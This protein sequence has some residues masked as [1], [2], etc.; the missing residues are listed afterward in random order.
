MNECA[1]YL[2]SI[3]AAPLPEMIEQDPAGDI[4]VS[5][6]AFGAVMEAYVAER[7]SRGAVLR[8]AAAHRLRRPLPRICWTWCPMLS[9]VVPAMH[10]KRAESGHRKRRSGCTTG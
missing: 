5:C 4:I 3:L 2:R 7:C 1:D 6:A 10:R 8:A 9:D